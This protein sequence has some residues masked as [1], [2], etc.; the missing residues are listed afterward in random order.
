MLTTRNMDVQF[1]SGVDN[2]SDNKNTLQTQF[3]ELKN[4]RIGKIGEMTYRSGFQMITS[5]N[6]YSRNAGTGGGVVATDKNCVYT[7]FGKS[8]SVSSTANTSS[9]ISQEI[10]GGFS[11]V[12]G[13]RKT[14]YQTIAASDTQV[15]TVAYLDSTHVGILVIDAATNEIIYRST[16]TLLYTNA[17]AVVHTLCINNVFYLMYQNSGTSALVVHKLDTSNPT[18]PISAVTWAGAP[19][20]AGPAATLVISNVLYLAYPT[21]GTN[22]ALKSV[23]ASGSTFTTTATNATALTLASGGALAM[24][25]AASLYNTGVLAMFLS[26]TTAVKGVVYDSSLA[27]VGS[28]QSNSF[29]AD[30]AGRGY[31]YELDDGSR[32]KTLHYRMITGLYSAAMKTEY[33]IFDMNSTSNSVSFVT[34]NT[35]HQS[36][37]AAPAIVGAYQ[38]PVA[39]AE[40]N[41]LPTYG[42]QFA[43]DPT[44]GYS[45]P[46]ATFGV[47]NNLG[48]QST[49]NST[50]TG[51]PY[52]NGVSCQGKYFW[53]V[54][55]ASF[56]PS[57]SYTAP[58]LNSF[59][60]AIPSIEI[61]TSI[62]ILDPAEYPQAIIDESAGQANIIGV[63]ARHIHGYQSIPNSFPEMVL[64]PAYQISVV[65]TSGPGAGTYQY[66]FAKRFQSADGFISRSYSQFITAYIDAAHS[67]TFSQL[68]TSGL[69][70][71]GTTGHPNTLLELYRTEAN[72]SVLYLCNTFDGT[73]ASYNDTLVDAT[74]ITYAVC[75]LNGNTLVPEAIPSARVA[76][77]YKSRIAI[78]TADQ[79]SEVWF[80][81]PVSYPRSTSF[82]NGLRMIVPEAGGRITGMHQMDAALYIFK[83][84]AIF[85]V[86]GDPAGA[87][88]EG[89]T[90]GIP[91]VLYE[92]IGC[93]S[94]RS[95]VLT[96]NGL[97]FQSGKGFYLLQRNQQLQ[98]IG[99]GPYDLRTTSVLTGAVVS[100]NLSE[101]VVSYTDGS[102]PLAWALNTDT[103][104]W[105][106][107]SMNELVYGLAQQNGKV[108]MAMSKGLAQQTDYNYDTDSQGNQLD[109]ATD[110]TTGWIRLNGIA[111]YQRVKRLTLQMNILNLVG[112]MNVVIY[113]DYSYS[114]VQTVAVDI[115]AQSSG[116]F[117]LDIHLKVQKCE[118][119]AFQIVTNNG[120]YSIQGATLVLG[121]KTGRDKAHNSANHY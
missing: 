42:S 1:Q 33:L 111:G 16:V 75:E 87:T 24:C 109:I 95:V 79:E 103:G 70:F 46:L 37:W 121:V 119:L 15:C 57:T 81:R 39:I 118:A 61:Q 100:Q 90:L 101:I 106:K 63:Q 12:Y 113:T 78:V 71:D 41:T 38:I 35:P 96:Q 17:Q 29:A 22:W 40:S 31:A 117:E 11:R 65:G 97:V 76:C 10:I 91:Q 84:N 45:M 47:G 51:E 82:S 49:L 48:K 105:S 69:Y 14:G 52:P 80:S 86:Y 7:T 88:G 102:T 44:S 4:T 108:L 98:F 18:T 85:T 60:Y 28:I 92:G 50:S 58:S 6:D 34:S 93:N 27:Q 94:P 110:I 9:T 25:T 120:N 2:K 56:S 89:G 74:L 13:P 112:P 73:S 8:Y 67:V 59:Q 99:Q 43:F 116:V 107:W 5:T 104:S 20:V 66:V 55:I 53:P 23:T 19:T 32:G 114:S 68:N 115:S 21:S 62:V 26:S 64:D 54:P 83:S 36:V 3:I 77:S 72:G 30:I